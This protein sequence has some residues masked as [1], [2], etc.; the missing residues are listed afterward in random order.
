MRYGSGNRT[1]SP[2]CATENSQ[3]CDE[4]VEIIRNILLCYVCCFPSNSAEEELSWSLWDAFSLDVQ[5]EI[6]F[7]ELVVPTLKSSLT[8]DKSRLFLSFN[9]MC[10]SASSP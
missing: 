10:V 9:Y 1:R 6:V 4:D 8:H 5:S 3:R 2:F 7:G